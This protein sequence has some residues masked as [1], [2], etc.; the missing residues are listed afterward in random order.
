MKNT[1][2]PLQESTVHLLDALYR[3]KHLN[4]TSA[5]L[6]IQN[7]C[8]P[9]LETILATFR[10]YE[11][12]ELVATFV[13]NN[14]QL[15]NEAKKQIEEQKEETQQQAEVSEAEENQPFSDIFG[16]SFEF[17]SPFKLMKAVSLSEIEGAFSNALSELCGE[18]LK[19]TIEGLDKKGSSWRERVE[20]KLSV[21]AKEEFR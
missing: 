9:S 15:I 17:I 7:G 14:S 20:V 18:E 16:S 11:Y 21:A 6:S 1:I 3:D 2:H 13:R 10:H 19:I 4:V 8:Y 12:E 5:M